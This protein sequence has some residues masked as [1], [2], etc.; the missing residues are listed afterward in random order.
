MPAP[1]MTPFNEEELKR[2]LEEKYGGYQM[3]SMG[4]PQLM[5]SLT[6]STS[7]QVPAIPQFQ[8]P[9]GMPMA[10]PQLQPEVPPVLPEMPPL[11]LPGMEQQQPQQPMFDIPKMREDDGFKQFYKTQKAKIDEIDKLLEQEQGKG[12]SIG[13]LLGMAFA[14]VGQAMTGEKYLDRTLELTRAAKQDKLKALNEQRK[15][16]LNSVEE[17][18]SDK[19]IEKMMDVNSDISKMYRELASTYTGKPANTFEKMSAYDISDIIPPIQAMYEAK[20]KKIERDIQLNQASKAKQ[21]PPNQVIAVTD[22]AAV[23]K[24]LPDIENTI[25]Q[26]EELFGPIGGRLAQANPY[27]E[28]GQSVDAQMRAASQAFGRFMEGGVLR[29]EDE[30]K[31]RKMFPQL[32]DRI[33]T[34]KNKLAIIRRLLA[35]R[36][37]D[38]RNAL[39]A[40]GYDTSGL[41]ELDIPPSIWDK[42]KEKK[43]EGGKPVQKKPAPYGPIVMQKGKTYKWDGT[44]YVEVGGK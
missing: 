33:G 34:A 41:L 31:Y 18:R 1:L 14:G 16:E 32:G 25:A 30:E 8:S 9:P 19:K 39:T 10:Q 23:G 13:E 43:M 24:M 20:M 6:P 22:G 7:T 42:E 4:E 35:Q 38:T 44:D 29:K 5:G 37:T 27:D 17:F 15:K 3:P 40:S 28:R 11:K 21:L 12:P 2:K 36:Y 26:N